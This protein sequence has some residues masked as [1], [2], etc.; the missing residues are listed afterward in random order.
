MEPGVNI[1]T[2]SVL[3]CLVS[4]IPPYFYHS[5]RHQ[6]LLSL[7]HWPPCCPNQ[8]RNIRCATYHPVLWCVQSLDAIVQLSFGFVDCL[9]S[10]LRSHVIYQCQRSSLGKF[11]FRECFRVHYSHHSRLDGGRFFRLC[12][13][14]LL[15]LV[16]RGGHL[17][18]NWCP[19]WSFWLFESSR[20]NM[21]KQWPGCFDDL[22]RNRNVSNGT[23][24]PVFST[25]F[26]LYST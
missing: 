15:E 25:T 3:L 22:F 24:L 4:L 26:L 10:H 12:R 17:Q 20:T 23:H 16:L 7:M 8:S 5:D 21:L 1:S 13:Q 2:H 18:T 11:R 9:P 14:L 19:R 6:Q